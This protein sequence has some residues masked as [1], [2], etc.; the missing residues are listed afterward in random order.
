MRPAAGQ[1]RRSLALAG[2]R[3]W[4]NNFSPPLALGSR[5]EPSGRPGMGYRQRWKAGTALVPAVVAAQRLLKPLRLSGPAHRARRTQ[6][7]HCHLPRGAGWDPNIWPQRVSPASAGAAGVAE[8][9]VGGKV[10]FLPFWLLE[11]G[12]LSSFRVLLLGL[13]SCLSSRGC[14]A[15]GLETKGAQKKK[16]TE[17]GR[18]GSNSGKWGVWDL[19][20]VFVRSNCFFFSFIMGGFFGNPGLSLDLGN[21]LQNQTPQPLRAFPAWDHGSSADQENA[22]PKTKRRQMLGLA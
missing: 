5:A 18:L 9:L 16:Q 1:S 20:P 3:R 15:I 10:P 11:K 8:Q 6:S 14:C 21:A 2:Q 19:V 12:A 4:K 22:Q 7:P 13:F 17:N